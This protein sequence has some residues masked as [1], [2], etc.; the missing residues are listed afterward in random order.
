MILRTAD[1]ERRDGRVVNRHYDDIYSSTDADAEV[2]RVFLAPADVEA[3]MRKQD[4]FTIAE[5]GFGSGRNFLVAAALAKQCGCRLHFLSVEAQ[6]IAADALLDVLQPTADHHLAADLAAHYPPALAGWHQRVFDKGRIVL[7]LFLGEAAAF[8]ADLRDRHRS[9]VDAWFL[10]GF[11]PD[12]NP[13]MWAEPLLADVASTTR[14]N[15]TVT[16]FTSAGRVRRALESGGFSMR[17]VDQRPHKRESLVGVMTDGI[18]PAQPPR[19]VHVVGA[20]IAGCAAARHF[21]DA[22]LDVLLSDQAERPASAASSVVAM[23]HARLLGDGSAQADWRAAAY[24]YATHWNAHRP[25]VRRTG[26]LQRPGPNLSP[27]KLF[28]IGQAFAGSGS[29]VS[30]GDDGDEPALWFPDAGVVDLPALCDDLIRHD[31]IEARFGVT[32]FQTDLPTIFACGAGT[33]ALPQF[34]TLPIRPLWGQID[35]VERQPNSAEISYARIGDGY[36]A[37]FQGG[38]VV[39]STYEYEPWAEEIATARNLE[40]LHGEA[41]TWRSRRRGA[42]AVA[43]DR[44]P[45]VGAMEGVWISSAHGSM[46]ATSAYLSAAV[47]LHQIMGWIPPVTRRIEALLDPGRFAKRRRSRAR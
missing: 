3:R 44:T 32:S 8:A 29:W 6:P 43:N 39:G 25:A 17:R 47:L 20:G 26:A 35:I 1:I 31:R 40:K 36:I 13:D 7:S 9:G 33:T 21:A 23:Q 24:L 30:L 5:L 18:W 45:V 2:H 28:G 42:R 14:Q 16:T 22:G 46:G 37:P 38:C 41:V 4:R 15:G 10:D 27:E 11:A 12:R 19:Q 34:S